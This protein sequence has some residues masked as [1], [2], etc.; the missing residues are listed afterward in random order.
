DPRAVGSVVRAVAP[1]P[2]LARAG[3]GE[4]APPADPET[5]EIDRAN[6]GVDTLQEAR[7]VD[8]VAAEARDLALQPAGFPPSLALVGSCHQ[9]GFHVDDADLGIAGLRRD[10]RAHGCGGA[11]RRRAVT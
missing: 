8:R 6:G 10:R 11:D 9:R 7:I 2:R 4:Q 3:G 5:F 1:P